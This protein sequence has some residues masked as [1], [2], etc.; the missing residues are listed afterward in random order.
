[1]TN[2]LYTAKKYWNGGKTFITI[3]AMNNLNQNL[4]SQRVISTSS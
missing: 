1:M 2:V 3:G 4:D